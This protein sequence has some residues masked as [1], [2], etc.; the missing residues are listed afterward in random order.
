[1]LPRKDTN[2]SLPNWWLYSNCA[3]IPL[4]STLPMLA[5]MPVAKPASKGTLSRE[6]KI[7]ERLSL[8]SSTVTL[9]SLNRFRSIPKSC[10]RTFDHWG[11]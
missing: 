3:S 6:T 8:N 2:Q 5:E 7:F 11:L 10:L 1:M 9:R 4:F